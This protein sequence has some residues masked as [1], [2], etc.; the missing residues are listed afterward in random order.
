M[1]AADRPWFSVIVPTS[2]RESLR[3]TLRRLRAED[4]GDIEVL[5]VADGHQPTAAKIARRKAARWRAL[6]YF[7]TEPTRNWGNAQRMVGIDHARGRY[8]CFID[9]DDVTKRGA[10]RIIREAVQAHPDRIILFR[11]KY[12]RGTILWREPRLAHGNVSTQQ[13]VVPNLP[14]KV[15]SWLTQ[16]RRDSDF[17]FIRECV[18]LQGEPVWRPEVIA[19][20]APLGS[21]II[22]RANLR[23]AFERLRAAA[24]RT[25][26]SR[27]A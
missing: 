3:R 9:D 13:I 19:L 16:D 12:L 2:G 6:R 25:Q 20:V 5:V 10:F 4:R 17:D 21:R 14:G 26:H 11:M 8:L 24:H 1:N 18:E 22:G 15:G 7:E 23:A 27:D